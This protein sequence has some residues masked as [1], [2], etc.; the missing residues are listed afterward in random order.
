MDFRRS[1]S[2]EATAGEA[3]PAVLAA[4]M[5]KQKSCRRPICRTRSPLSGSPMQAGTISPEKSKRKLQKVE[6]Q[7]ER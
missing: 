3:P 5:A 6:T 4:E 2:V 1:G 7:V